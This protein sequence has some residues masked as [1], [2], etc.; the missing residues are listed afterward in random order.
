MTCRML[1]KRYELYYEK[2][3][4]VV[5]YDPR[6]RFYDYNDN[7]KALHNYMNRHGW[8]RFKFT[9]ILD[10]QSSNCPIK[11]LCLNGELQCA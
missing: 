8:I 11:I 9:P 4:A 3:T 6:D 10:L 7:I 5:L 2:Q 1:Y